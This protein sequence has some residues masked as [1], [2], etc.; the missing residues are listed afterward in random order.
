MDEVRRLYQCV[1]HEIILETLFF[2]I[3]YYFVY[4]YIL[5]HIDLSGRYQTTFLKKN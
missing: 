2:I 5:H 1:Y 3:N 4:I